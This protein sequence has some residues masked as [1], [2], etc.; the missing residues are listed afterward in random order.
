[1]RRSPIRALLLFCLCGLLA[2]PPAA[3]PWGFTMHRVINR[4]AIAN[5]PAD[6]QDFGQWSAELEAL[7]TAADERKCCEA[8][9]NI[10]HYID[11]DDYPEFF[12]GTFPRKYDKALSQYGRA[13]L[14]G[15]GI[16]PW[17]LEESYRKLVAEFIAGD[18]AA[19]V[20][21]AGDIGHY[22]GD[23]HQ[24]LHLTTNYDGQESGQN[25]IHSRYETRLTGR[26]LTEFTPLGG[27]A[28]LLADPLGHT[29]EWIDG[30]YAGVARILAADLAARAEAGGSTTSEIYYTGLWDRLGQDTWYWVA[31]ASRDIA[32]IWYTAWIEAGSPPLPGSTPVEPTSW[33]RIKALSG[34]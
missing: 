15:N 5:L 10:R 23:L 25:G 14:E 18:W 34:R 30:T 2:W 3:Q 20:A 1:M 22:A 13:R 26:H 16:G 8:G 27:A 7:S 29:F 32:S 9:E 19:A 31:S 21:D 6:F 28:P 11:I 24:P 33:S 4:N 12:S 17:A